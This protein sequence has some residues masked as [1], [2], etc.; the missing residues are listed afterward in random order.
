MGEYG[1]GEEEEHG[2]S[3]SSLKRQGGELLECLVECD[4]THHRQHPDLDRIASRVEVDMLV[5]GDPRLVG[6]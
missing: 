4:C 3:Q 6:P 2:V 5:R 1:R